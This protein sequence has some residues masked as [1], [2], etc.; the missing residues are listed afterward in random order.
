MVSLFSNSQITIVTHS[1][2]M[3]GDQLMW[4]ESHGSH[5]HSPSCTPGWFSMASAPVFHKAEQPWPQWPGDSEDELE[6]V[7]AVEVLRP[8]SRKGTISV[9]ISPG[10]RLYERAFSTEIKQCSVSSHVVLQCGGLVLANRN[11]E[12]KHE[13]YS[14]EAWLSWWEYIFPFPVHSLFDAIWQSTRN[15]IL[16]RS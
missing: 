11:E 1:C 5:S 2:R 8:A 12:Q 6:A 16:L 14:E 15:H 9:P 13:T 7:E 4:L 3:L 10:S